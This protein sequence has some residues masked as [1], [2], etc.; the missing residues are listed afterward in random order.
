MNRHAGPTQD[1]QP[2]AIPE[3]S[4][5]ERAKTL[6]AQHDTGTLATVSR[7]HAG[8]PFA[9]LMPYALD[10]DGRAL[11]LISSMAVHT[12]NLRADARASLLVTAGTAGV[13]PLAAARVTLVGDAVPILPG[14]VGTARERYLL[15]HP[16]AASWVDFD[17][18]AFWRLVA[19]DVYFIGGFGAMGWV[20]AD[21]FERARP[22]PLATAAR[23]II[24]HMNRDHADALLV[25]ARVFAHAP[26]DEA[27]MASVDRL[28]FTLRLRAGK[29]RSSVRIPFPREVA[30]ADDS[31]AVLIEM[32][33]QARG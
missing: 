29:R 22:D 16:A 6:L 25:Y 28:G 13:D 19:A 10:D 21:G 2:D 26:A 1:D 14:D 12:Q 8:H 33:R 18:F 9:S 32:L 3:P 30:S 4:F 27:T 17:D 23:S 5:A 31:R 20:D 11:L 24:E 15:R 7:K